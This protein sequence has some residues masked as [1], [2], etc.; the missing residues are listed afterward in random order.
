ML[1]G[2]VK[3][4]AV[5]R[6]SRP[7]IMSAELDVKVHQESRGLCVFLCHAPAKDSLRISR[8]L[9]ASTPRLHDDS[10]I[11]SELAQSVLHAFLF[12]VWTVINVAGVVEVRSKE[13][14]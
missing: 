7:E 12:L 13:E 2:V 8:T 10:S 4:A 6:G 1:Q 5:A 9:L 11:L 3:M 14:E